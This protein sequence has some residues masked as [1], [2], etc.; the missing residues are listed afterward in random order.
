MSLKQQ[1]YAV[2]HGCHDCATCF[3]RQEYDTESTLY[4]TFMAPKRPKCMSVYMDECVHLYGNQ[5]KYTEARDVWDRWAKNR[6]VHP[7]GICSHWKEKK[8]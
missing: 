2:Q 1:G 7:C 5:K 3:E 6:E 8:A 4:C